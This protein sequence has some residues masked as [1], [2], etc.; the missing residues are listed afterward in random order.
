[1]ASDVP[2]LKPVSAYLLWRTYFAATNFTLAK[3]TLW[4]LFGHR[5]KT[6]SNWTSTDIG[7]AMSRYF[8]LPTPPI[9]PFF[10]AG[11]DLLSGSFRLPVVLCL[12]V[13]APKKDSNRPAYHMLYSHITITQ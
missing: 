5:Q 12:V 8:F 10:A 1:M 9:L 11:F 4:I 13:T 3:V 6:L 7:Q 2:I